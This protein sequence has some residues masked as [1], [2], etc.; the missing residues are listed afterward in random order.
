MLRKRN[1]GIVVSCF[2]CMIAVLLLIP[3]HY[4]SHKKIHVSI[5]DVWTCF[6]ELS[7]DSMSYETIYEHPFF[8]NLKLAHEKTGAKFTLYVFERA[9]NYSIDDIPLKYIE[10]LRREKDWLRI[11]YHVSSDTATRE[12]IGFLSSFKQS[13]EHVNEKLGGANI[14]RLQYY[15]ATPE[16]VSYLSRKGKLTLLSA[17]DDRRSYSLPLSL[18]DSLIKK[19]SIQYNNIN[20]ERT[21]IRIEKP[22]GPLKELYLNRNDETIVLFTHEWALKNKWNKLEMWFYLF[23]FSI[24]N[25]DFIIN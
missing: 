8:M 17:D 18:N 15:Y 21:D 1:W 10:Q 12:D 4:Y 19:E 6:N 5:D 3:Y 20:F 14:L 13:F 25:C 24:Y 7:K 22:D 9:N 16:E 2:V 23:F 11:G